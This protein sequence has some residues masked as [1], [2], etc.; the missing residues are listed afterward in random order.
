MNIPLKT[1]QNEWVRLEPLVESDFERLYET[2]SDPLIWEQHPNPDR[3][4]REVFANFFKGAME[5]KGAFIIFSE[6]DGSVIGSSRFYDFKQK[7]REIKIGYTFFNRASWG[8]PFNK[9]TKALMIEYAFQFVDS[10]IFHVG[11]TNFRSQKAME[12]IGGV[13]IGTEVVAY[14]GEPD[15]VNFVYQIKKAEA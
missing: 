5:S 3:Y 12:K 11:E 1:L 6:K 2:A 10:I 4:K 9:S 13:K 7:E 8:Q 14:Y 15:R